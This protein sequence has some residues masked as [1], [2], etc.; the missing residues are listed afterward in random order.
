MI[1]QRL[2]AALRA[3]CPIRGVSV[4]NA[5]DKATWRIDF[6]P[7]ATAQ[8][9]T[10]AAAVLSAFDVAA[11]QQ[12]DVA[13]QQRRVTD[14]QELADARIDNAVGTLLDMTPAQRV[15]YARNNFPSLTLAEQNR[16]GMILNMLSVAMRPQIRS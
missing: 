14:Q 5:A 4:G 13:D 7:A 8:Q 16:L 3:V 9:R 1:I 6:D 2:D 15:Q 11:A 10:D 12:Q